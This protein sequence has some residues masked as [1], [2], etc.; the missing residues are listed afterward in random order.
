M[1]AIAG[2]VPVHNLPM[3]PLAEEDAARHTRLAPNDS[4]ISY[5]QA[6]VAAATRPTD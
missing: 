4:G 1:M 5:G 3:K 2:C 6:A